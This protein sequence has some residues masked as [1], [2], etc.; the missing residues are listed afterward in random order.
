MGIWSL[1]RTKRPE[2]LVIG[3]GNPGSRYAATRHNIGWRVVDRL[4][5]GKGLRKIWGC[6]GH[7]CRLVVVDEAGLNRQTILLVKPST[8]MN[9]SGLAVEILSRRF[10]LAPERILILLDDVDLEPGRIRLRSSGGS[11]GHRG[12]SSVMEY[13][14]TEQVPRLRLG[15]GRPAP[16]QSMV[17][18]V[19]SPF[20]S[21]DTAAIEAMLSRAVEAVNAWCWLEMDRAMNLVNTPASA[22]GAMERQAI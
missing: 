4:A 12:M 7:G 1:F 17:E 13:L 18:H 22:S 8:F 16:G 20:E 11:A 3:L 15:V 19:L 14:G 21:V 2:R 6:P 9:N 10:R 5:D